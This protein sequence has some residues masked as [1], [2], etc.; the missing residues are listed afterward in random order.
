MHKITSHMLEQ[1][2]ITVCFTWLRKREQQWWRPHGPLPNLIALLYHTRDHLSTHNRST[3]STL[4]ALTHEFTAPTS[5]MLYV[6]SLWKIS[7]V[8]K[9]SWAPL[10]VHWIHPS[11][12]CIIVKQILDTISF[13]QPMSQKRS[14]GGWDVGQH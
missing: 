5:N 12:S 10:L 3:K 2:V 8:T 9:Y 1:A 13:H 7:N 11:Y 4:C 14:L 6:F